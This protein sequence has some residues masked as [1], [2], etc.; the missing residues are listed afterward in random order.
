VIS[1]AEVSPDLLMGEVR[2]RKPGA[3]GSSCCKCLVKLN[4][5]PDWILNPS[6]P[7]GFERQECSPQGGSFQLP[8]DAAE[9]S[10][11]LIITWLEQT[12]VCI[13]EVLVACPKCGSKEQESSQSSCQ[14]SD[15]IGMFWR[16]QC[17]KWLV[18][19]R[20]GRKV[21]QCCTLPMQQTHFSFS[22]AAR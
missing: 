18:T 13:F 8:F 3:H 4:R 21:V 7:I 6:Q 22:L 1:C 2:R 5:F 20:L 19:V 16:L 11:S 10:Q 12:Q 17:D 9:L 15:S 14:S